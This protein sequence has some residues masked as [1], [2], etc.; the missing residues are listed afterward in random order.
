MPDA[1]LMAETV[2]VDVF[3]FGLLASK[4]WKSVTD[5]IPG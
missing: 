4:L 1:D 3:F 2:S 5:G